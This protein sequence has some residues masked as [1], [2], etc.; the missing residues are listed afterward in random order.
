MVGAARLEKL[1]A[2]FEAGV[3]ILLFIFLLSGFQA[4]LWFFGMVVGGVSIHDTRVVNTVRPLCTEVSYEEIPLQISFVLLRGPFQLVLPSTHGATC[5]DFGVFTNLRGGEGLA[6]KVGDPITELVVAF[7]D[8]AFLLAV[9]GL[10]DV[11]RCATSIT[12]VR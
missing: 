4:L 6:R 9:K 1:R 8:E 11:K 10:I 7:H 2:L 5:V 3:E 12:M